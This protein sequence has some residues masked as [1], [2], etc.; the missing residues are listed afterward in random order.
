M[1][2]FGRLDC[3]DQL[4]GCRVAIG[5]RQNG[6]AKPVEFQHLGCNF[7]VRHGRV[8]EIVSLL[9]LGRDVVGRTQICGFA[10]GRT[11]QDDLDAADLKPPLI[12]ADRRVAYIANVVLARA[13]ADEAA[14]ARLADIVVTDARGADLLQG[15][16][17]SLIHGD[18]EVQSQAILT[19]LVKALKARL[20]TAPPE[21][22]QRFKALMGTA[23]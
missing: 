2:G 19:K 3:V 12:H 11:V 7:V 13:T 4:L 16:S 20:K 23:E 22:Q 15:F 21:V 18:D 10:L 8:A 14:I 17:W 5:M 9:A 1:R 6:P